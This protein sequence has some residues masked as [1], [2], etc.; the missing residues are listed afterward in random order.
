MHFFGS[1]GDHRLRVL[2]AISEFGSHNFAPNKHMKVGVCWFI[3]GEYVDEFDDEVAVGAGDL[4]EDIGLNVA[5]DG[6]VLAKR[7]RAEC[8]DIVAVEAEALVVE[9]IFAR[10][11]GQGATL[12]GNWVGGVGDVVVCAGDWCAVRNEAFICAEIEV[13]FFGDFGRPLVE[14]SPCFCSAIED[15]CFGVD[16]LGVASQKSVEEGEFDFVLVKGAGVATPIM[17]AK[18]LSGSAGPH[19][20]VPRPHDEPVVGLVAIEFGCFVAGHWAIAV[21]GIK[22]SADPETCWFDI[23]ELS[24]D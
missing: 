8:E 20:V 10:S 12:V 7:F 1:V 21:F 22:K 6:E 4:G 14:A 17:G 11:S 13:N 3:G 16:E 2:E 9:H 24:R 19:S 18:F 23:F 5:G 15:G